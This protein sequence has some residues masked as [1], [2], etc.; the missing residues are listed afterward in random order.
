MVD[1]V[2]M[3]YNR[4][5]FAPSAMDRNDNRNT[6]FFPLLRSTTPSIAPTTSPGSSLSS[7]TEK[8]DHAGRET[9]PPRALKRFS[10]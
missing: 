8:E 5:C 3:S 9:E 7:S 6:A 1:E 4:P 2:L 10:S